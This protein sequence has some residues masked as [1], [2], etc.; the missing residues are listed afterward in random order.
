M[1]AKS[2]HKRQWLASAALCAALAS[3][4]A[5]AQSN[6]NARGGIPDL[7]A[8]SGFWNGADLERRSN[9]SATQNDGMHGTYAEY[10]V[11]LDR[12]ANVMGITE[13][14]VTGLSCTYAGSYT[15]GVSPQ[16]SGAYRCSDGKQGDFQAQSFL[17]TPHE[18]SI[19]LSIK[20]NSTETCDIDAILGGSRY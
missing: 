18:M 15:P 12:S 2:S 7:G 3:L 6:P 11:S 1:T 10:F 14:G 17:V 8:L 16:W 4:A 20:L 5:A 19:R 13:T 9:C